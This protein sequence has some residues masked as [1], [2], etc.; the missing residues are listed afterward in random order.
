MGDKVS[1]GAT[2][3]KDVTLTGVLAGR[4]ENCV[5]ANVIVVCLAK[6]ND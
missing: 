5:T 3:R 6:T 1:T 2:A 4:T